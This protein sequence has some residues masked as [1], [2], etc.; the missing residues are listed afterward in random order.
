[1]SE[2]ISDKTIEKAT[3]AP[4]QMWYTRL[5][6]MGARD[7][8]HKDI[9]AKLVS[10]YQVAGWWA[11]SLTVRYEQVIGRRKIGQNNKGEFSVGVSKTISA[12]M[13]EAF[14]WWLTTVQSRTEFNGIEIISSSTTE[15]EKWRHYRAA[16]KDG[17]RVVV[18][19]YAKTSAKAG[20]GL[21][22]EKLTSSQSAEDWRAYW[23][24]LL[25]SGQ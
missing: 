10:Q 23:K 7:L 16:L 14:H 25:S 17:S 13:N 5:E 18:G 11:Q 22:H 21:Q 20:L 3:G 19:I 12:T 6:K 9:A 8:S 15:T 2:L 24:A 4:W 1:M